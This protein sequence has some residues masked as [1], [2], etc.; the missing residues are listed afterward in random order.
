M[1][2]CHRQI[3][4]SVGLG[5]DPSGCV[6]FKS[7]TVTSMHT[8]S[9]ENLGVSETLQTLIL[10]LVKYALFDFDIER[11]IGWHLDNNLNRQ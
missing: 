7:S 1:P 9:V 10:L 6:F 5:W 4:N 3:P 11:E 8:H 2:R